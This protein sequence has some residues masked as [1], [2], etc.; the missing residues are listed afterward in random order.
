MSMLSM[1]NCYRKFLPKYVVHF[2]YFFE[3]YSCYGMFLESEM[4]VIPV[5]KMPPND[6]ELIA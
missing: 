5:E 2:P 3:E 4:R 1:I 6:C